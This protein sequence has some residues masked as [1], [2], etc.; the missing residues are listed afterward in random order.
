MSLDFSGRNLRGQNFKGQDLSEANFRNADIRGANFTNALLRG[1][2][3]TG[4]KAGIQRRWSVILTIAS[5][6]LAGL[7]ALSLGFVANL[8][9]YLFA[10]DIVRNITI[11]PGLTALGVL[12]IFLFSA[13]RKGLGIALNLAVVAIAVA[14]I[15][16]SFFV[17]AVAASVSFIIAGTLIFAIAGIIATTA[18]VAMTIA[19]SGKVAGHITVFI[20]AILSA[21][22]AVATVVAAAAVGGASVF[23]VVLVLVLALISCYMGW[24][25]LAKGEKYSFIRAIAIGWATIGGTSFRNADLTYVDFSRATL[26]SSDFRNA[27]LNGINWYGARKLDLAR[28]GNSVLLS[29]AIRALLVTKNGYGQSYIGANLHGVNLQEAD[30]RYANL[31]RADLSGAI[32]KGANLSFSNLTKVLATGAD[33][34][35][36]CITGAC[37]QSWNI[38]QTTNL[39]DVNCEFVFLS[40]EFNSYGIRERLPH[41]PD[42]VF[43]SGEFT[44]LFIGTLN[45]VDLIFRGGLNRE[46][47]AE[48]LKNV[49]AIA[50]DTEFSIQSLQKKDDGIL[51]TLSV[52]SE[53]DKSEIEQQFSETYQLVLKDL[54][55]KYKAELQAKD[56]AVDIYRRQLVNLEEII[57]KLAS[58]PIV[59]DT[60]QTDEK[61]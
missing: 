24:D 36:A 13:Y 31:K 56:R 45:T 33:F 20:I 48:A 46:A 55:E 52:P 28:V 50:G 16:T 30:L 59:I 1:A 10:S 25:A 3:F 43:T 14:G 21:A 15:V 17:G 8:T 23:G 41:R 38:D 49:Q 39:N 7:S 34:T 11:I 53:V 32:L 61:N 42:K 4:A 40:E 9:I 6:L 57:E 58:Q 5:W 35:R 51:L 12:A 19:V 54:E 26:K 60:K 27:R 22:T 29:P 37:I 44:R 47:F 2:N 18:T